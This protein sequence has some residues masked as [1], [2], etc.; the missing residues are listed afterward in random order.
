MPLAHSKNLTKM[1]EEQHPRSF[2]NLLK[3]VQPATVHTIHQKTN[4]GHAMDVTA[5]L[6]LWKR[7]SSET[8][9]EEDERTQEEEVQ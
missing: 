9:E 6:L 7:M 4:L 3:N 2:Q 1:K 8:L 5:S